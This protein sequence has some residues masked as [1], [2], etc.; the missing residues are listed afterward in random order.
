VSAE[1]HPWAEVDLGGIETVQ[2]SGGSVT[3]D[4]LSVPYAYATLTIPWPGEIAEIDPR[5][6]IRIIIRA[7]NGGH[8]E[9]IPMGYGRGGYGHGPYGHS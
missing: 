6:D 7:G 3:L 8:W 4:A 5:D 1:L 9:D 2:P